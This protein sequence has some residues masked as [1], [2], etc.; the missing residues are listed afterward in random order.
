MNTQCTGASAQAGRAQKSKGNSPLG[1]S[2]PKR[3]AHKSDGSLGMSD[4]P[5]T[6]VNGYQGQGDGK[7]NY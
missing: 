5:K 3:Q 4:K 1:K 7:G 6:Q 2:S